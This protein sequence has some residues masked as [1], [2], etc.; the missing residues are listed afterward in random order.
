MMKAMQPE[1][2]TL[3]TYNIFY[4]RKYGRGFCIAQWM[5]FD[6]ILLTNLLDNGPVLNK[7]FG[8][9]AAD[10]M[11]LVSA[12]GQFAEV[13]QYLALAKL[14]CHTII[15]YVKDMLLQRN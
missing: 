14:I 1:S 7:F 13:G 6:L 3:N 4:G 15:G 9:F 8:L 12:T 10:E 5:P 2:F 11:K